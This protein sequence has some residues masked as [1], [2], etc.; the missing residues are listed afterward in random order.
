M[1]INND[2]L[3][4][5]GSS[6]L[7]SSGF[8]VNISTGFTSAAGRHCLSSTATAESFTSIP[9]LTA[10]LEGKAYIIC[11]EMFYLERIFRHSF[12]FS[13]PKEFFLGHRLGVDSVVQKCT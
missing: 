3:I 11:P 13:L 9:Q 4:E 1:Y 5:S 7:R 2:T 6:L 12:A 10:V 8:R